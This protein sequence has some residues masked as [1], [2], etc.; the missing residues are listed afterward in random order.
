MARKPSKNGRSSITFDY[1]KGVA[2]GR[3]KEIAE[4]VY[5]I[6][7][8]FLTG[9]QSGCPKCKAGSDRWRVFS[10]FNNTGGA[11]CN[12]CGRDLGDGFK[13]GDWFCGW[14]KDET[15][16]RVAE[17]LNI[18]GARLGANSANSARGNGKPSSD[19]AAHLAFEP[20]NELL[21]ANWCARKSPITLAALTTCHAR[22]ARYR[23]QHTVIALPVWGSQLTAADP[24]GWAL[25][26]ISGGTLPKWE[27]NKETGRWEIVGQLKVKL[28]QG[29]QPGLIGPV[30]RIAAAAE[31][32]KVE[33]PS[34][35]LAW[36]SLAEIPADHIA[37]TNANGAGERPQRW[38]LELLR[39]KTNVRVAHDA[40]QPGQSGAIGYEKDGKHRPGWAERAARNIL[41]GATD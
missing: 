8:E 18:D 1:V 7:G 29:S 36:W 17:F 31:I 20:L 9:R 2:R 32:W 4:Q 37:I 35:L 34:D 10:D 12:Q 33:G 23:N 3:W 14:K 30:E 38:M 13:L 24:V 19:P 40:D 11:I 39:G 28:T 15:L 6:P 41:N 16:N 27:K 5:H 22:Q 25:Y 26:N 21:V